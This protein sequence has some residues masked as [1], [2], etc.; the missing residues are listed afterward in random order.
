MHEMHQFSSSCA[1][2]K[3]YPGFCSP[4]IHSVVSNEPLRDS[5]SPDKTALTHRL[6]WA[7]SVCICRKTH[8]I[9]HWEI[10]KV[11]C[12]YCLLSGAMSLKT[13]SIIFQ[14]KLSPRERERRTEN[15]GT[16][17]KRLTTLIW[18]WVR[19]EPPSK[20]HDGRSN[21]QKVSKNTS[22][23]N[24]VAL[25]IPHPTREWNILSGA[26]DSKNHQSISEG[27]TC[28]Y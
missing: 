18:L 21:P 20:N 24:P 13:L 3:S 17:E 16:V 5:K 22:P 12:G 7:I 9:F 19:Q 6:I 27:A 2:A 28:K 23:Y 10:R 1:R 14:I 8:H 15:N 4:F 25:M 26:M 11:L